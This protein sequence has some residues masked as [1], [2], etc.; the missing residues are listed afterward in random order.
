MDVEIT[1]FSA[2]FTSEIG[3]DG[4][5]EEWFYS[6]PPGEPFPTLLLFFFLF[7]AIKWDVFFQSKIKIKGSAPNDLPPWW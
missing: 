7:S 2:N 6:R 5:R 3:D 1:V 4:N